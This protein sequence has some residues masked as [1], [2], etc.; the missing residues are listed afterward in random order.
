MVDVV[1]CASVLYVY[2]CTCVRVCVCVCVFE[3]EEKA[4]EV[5]G[6]ANRT[7]VDARDVLGS[8]PQHLMPTTLRTKIYETTYWLASCFGLNAEGVVDRGMSARLLLLLLLLRC[9]GE[10]R[11]PCE[12]TEEE[13]KQGGKPL[14][15]GTDSRE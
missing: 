12:E 14:V 3:E 15:T 7:D 11:M 10:M 5:K 4:L 8:N 1:W 6:M 9:R 13:E 2:V